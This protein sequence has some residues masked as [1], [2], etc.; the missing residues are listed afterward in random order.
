MRKSVL[1]DSGCDL[2]TASRK[3]LGVELWPIAIERATSTELDLRDEAALLKLY[4]EGGGHLL[5]AKT[6]PMDIAQ[7]RN[8]FFAMNADYDELLY[9]SIMTQ[10]SPAMTQAIKSFDALP[11]SVQASRIAHA[12]PA[13]ALHTFDSGQLFAGYA[14]VGAYAA[15]V[16]SKRDAPET[17]K[18]MSAIVQKISAYLIPGEL[19]TIRERAR[20]KGEKSVSFLGY[21]IGT[22]L[23]IKPM[24]ACRS[25]LTGAVAK[26]RGMSHAIDDLIATIISQINTGK[27][28]VPLITVVYGGNL[29]DLKKIPAVLRL[30]ATCKSAE[31]K[32]LFSMMSVTG[33]VNIGPGGF[34]IAVCSSETP[35]GDFS[36]LK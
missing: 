16:Y 14:W 30:R 32:L 15:F 28:L 27:L 31:V 7:A 8:R 12:Q 18:A 23:D 5:D 11:P 26:V 17:I 2:S 4:D 1:V 3:A 35:Y 24:I 9:V 20:L 19:K 33:L 36:L 6:K 29:D 22:A 21:A 10:R 13:F 34:S 25:G